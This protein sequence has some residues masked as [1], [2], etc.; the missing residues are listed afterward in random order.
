MS[1]VRP[2]RDEL[3]TQ[4]HLKGMS[5]ERISICGERFAKS[6]RMLYEKFNVFLCSG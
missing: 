6:Y 1:E 2:L 3:S 5:S 4:A